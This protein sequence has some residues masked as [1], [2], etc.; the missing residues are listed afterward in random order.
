MSHW[1]YLDSTSLNHKYDAVRYLVTYDDG[2]RIINTYRFPKGVK[3]VKNYRHR[4]IGESKPTDGGKWIEGTIK[5][6]KRKK[7]QKPASKRLKS[8]W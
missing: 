8:Y 7:A 4:K 6:S 2:R 1:Q 5:R 3:W